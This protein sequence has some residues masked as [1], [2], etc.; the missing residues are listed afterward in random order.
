MV[1]S[2]GNIK[3]ILI[4]LITGLKGY[5]NIKMELFVFKSMDGINF[6]MLIAAVAICS[7]VPHFGKQNGECIICPNKLFNLHCTPNDS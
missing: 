6:I 2:Y 4:L 1:T 5:I 3:L 7:G